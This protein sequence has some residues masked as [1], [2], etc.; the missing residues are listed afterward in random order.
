[1]FSQE[2]SYGSLRVDQFSGFVVGAEGEVERM[3]SAGLYYLGRDVRSWE[4]HLVVS[5]D[6]EAHN[7]VGLYVCACSVVSNVD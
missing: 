2:S 3:Y 7:K 1:M 6:S 4:I 5:W